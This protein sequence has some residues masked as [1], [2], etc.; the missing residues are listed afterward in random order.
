MPIA[1]SCGGGQV[2]FQNACCSKDPRPACHKQ[3]VPDGC[4]G[5]YPPNCGQQQ[6]CCDDGNGDLIC[7]SLPCP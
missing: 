5:T 3:A 2:C 7:R 4:G 6:H 1:T